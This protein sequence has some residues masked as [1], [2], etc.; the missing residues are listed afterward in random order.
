M[1]RYFR[2][3]IDEVTSLGTLGSKTLIGA[4]FDEASDEGVFIS[5]LVAAYTIDQW[6]PVSDVGPVLVGVAHSDYSDAQIEAWIESTSSWEVGDIVATREVGRRLIR[7]IGILLGPIDAVQQTQLQNG[8][9]I[10]TKIGWNLATGD[11][12]KLW[13]YNMGAAAFATTNPNL[14]M[15]GHANLWRKRN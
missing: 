10:K 5:S 2:G 4:N 1:G 14:R 9:M 13:A 12:L 7:K 11:T 15:Q 3:E 6:T 8:R